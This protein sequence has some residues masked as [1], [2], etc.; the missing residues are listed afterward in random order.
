MADFP[1]FRSLSANFTP[2]PNQ[3]FDQVL[4]HY[5][6]RVVTVVGI[7]IRSTLGWSDEVTGE[8]RIEA[9]LPLSAFIRPELSENSAR[10]GLRE[11][12]AAGLV[13]ETARHTNRDG[14]RYAL[15]WADP[16]AQRQAIE[17]QRRADGDRREMSDIGGA[18]SGP[19]K[20]GP[21]NS[22]G[23]KTEPPLLKKEAGSKETVLD[24]KKPLTLNVPREAN[25]YK[26]PAGN[27]A[28]T[29]AAVEAV[30]G[31][32][33]DPGSRARFRQLREICE[34]NGLTASWDEALESTRK[35]IETG[36]LSSTPGAYFNGTLCRILGR[37]GCYVPIGKPEERE[38]VR[39]EIAASLF[40]G[41]DK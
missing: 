18:N 17:R 3:F 37:L 36:N 12:I 2:T 11:A 22:G 38:G 6:L 26:T 14:T 35:A 13:V 5:P 33:G 16:D 31:L 15:R 28:A 40:G 32:T 30:V 34:E 24:I 21:P 9:E 41:L 20:N 1:G 25:R 10:Q 7:L 23:P 19:P 39:S 8:R 29:L 27:L 4:G